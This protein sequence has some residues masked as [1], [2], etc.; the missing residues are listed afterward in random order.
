[1]VRELVTQIGKT[2]TIPNA[3]VPPNS[4]IPIVLLEPVTRAIQ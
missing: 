4:K 1:M 3:I 2:N